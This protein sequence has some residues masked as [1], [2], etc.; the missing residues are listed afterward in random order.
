MTKEAGRFS[1]FDA[2]EIFHM[3]RGRLKNF[4]EQGFITPTYQDE[5]DSGMKR[6]YFDHKGLYLIRL[7]TCFLDLGL[8][9][10]NASTWLHEFETEYRSAYSRTKKHPELICLIFDR[11]E[12]APFHVVSTETSLIGG[13]VSIDS[14][15]IFLDGRLVRKME[16]VSASYVLNF[17]RIVLE[18]DA[19]VNEFKKSHA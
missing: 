16:D 3:S 5:F 10:E 7:F 6:S 14:L 1:T 19:F 4:I 12:D 2:M 8:S 13:K 18:V 15:K 11:N 17:N 9:R